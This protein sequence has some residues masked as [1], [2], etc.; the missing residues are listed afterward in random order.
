MG[1]RAAGGAALGLLGLFGAWW[2]SALA[3]ESVNGGRCGTIMTVTEGLSDSCRDARSGHGTLVVALFFGVQALLVTSGLL[4]ATVGQPRFQLR[5]WVGPACLA[6]F[7]GCIVFLV[8][9][10]VTDAQR[11][12]G[13]P[14]T[15]AQ[16]WYFAGAFAMPVLLT[17]LVF[18]F[19]RQ[20]RNRS[21]VVAC[22]APQASVS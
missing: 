1:R 20:P 4:L 3:V 2:L 6:S 5:F 22:T 8:P 10:A 16:W 19:G 18:A 7:L 11:S 13:D 21:E 15:H 17:V 14:T 12:D 9:G